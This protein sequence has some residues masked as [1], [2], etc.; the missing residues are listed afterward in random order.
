[1]AFPVVLTSQT[2]PTFVAVP[3]LQHFTSA[4]LQFVG[5]PCSLPNVD[6]LQNLNLVKFEQ[7]WPD[8]LAHVFST[9]FPRQG[10]EA[11]RLPGAWFP[12]LLVKRYRCKMDS[13]CQQLPENTMNSMNSTTSESRKESLKVR[14]HAESIQN[15]KCLLYLL[16]YILGESSVTH[17]LPRL[18]HLNAAP[19]SMRTGPSQLA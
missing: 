1:M 2:V 13:L 17:T 8:Q 7:N 3:T 9:H 5:H 18:L 11:Q 14:P 15:S 19:W 16:F 12:V 10:L 6:V 4:N